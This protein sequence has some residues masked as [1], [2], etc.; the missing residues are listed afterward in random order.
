MSERTYCGD[1]P[2]YEFEDRH[3]GSDYRGDYANDEGNDDALSVNR[4]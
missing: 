2:E 4:R 3:N 1:G